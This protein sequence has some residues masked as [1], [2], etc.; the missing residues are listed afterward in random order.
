MMR[1][2][3]L[4]LSGCAFAA[5]T[6]PAAAQVGVG[7]GDHG[8]SVHLGDR[9]HYRDLGDRPHYRDHDRDDWRFR[10]HVREC[11]TFWRDGRRTTVCHG[12]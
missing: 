3:G 9:P 6:V 1:K 5:L 2:I 4:V 11:N 7:I 10:R 12:D 8:V